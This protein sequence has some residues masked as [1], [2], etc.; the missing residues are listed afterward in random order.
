MPEQYQQP[1]AS[2]GQ[3]LDTD[4]IVAIATAPG[5]AGIGIL[6]LSGPLAVTIAERV[7]GPG[8]VPRQATYRKFRDTTGGLLDS[9]LI[10]YFP[11]PHS[12]TGEDVVEFQG[13]GSPV[14]LQMI[15][16]ELLELGARLARPGEF[17][18][19]AFLNGKMDLAQAEAVADLISSASVEAARGANR[20]LS[21]EFSAR[22]HDIDAQVLELRI[23]VEAA[24]DFADEDIDLLA[25][26]QVAERIGRIIE[27]LNELRDA[28]A[29]GVILRDGI[30]LALIGPPNVGK[31]SLLNRLAGESRAIVS[32]VPGTTRDLIRADLDLG[33]LPVE[34]VD[35]AGLRESNDAV[36]QEG[37]RRALSE[38][39]DADIII[40]ISDL[41]V[42][43]EWSFGIEPDDYSRVLRVENKIDLSGA[44]R[45]G[46]GASVD[47]AMPVS[48]LTGEGI[49]SLRSAIRARAGFAPRGSLFTARKRHLVGIDD[50]LSSVKE[51]LVLATG[52][53]SGEL[54]AEEL[55]AAHS[56]LGEIVG[57][58]SSDALLGEIFSRFC[59][60]K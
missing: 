47:G 5:Q 45:T 9:G 60:G 56:A 55:K 13:H 58:M 25:E 21:G 46:E 53:L 30:K 51:A 40:L 34:I 8:L 2:S 7:A 24:I 20:S 26:G 38:A 6:R 15:Q 31:S 50:A 12:F 3:T 52:G 11:A 22:V 59:I 17:T 4:T 27:T 49:E 14:A 16:D 10:L 28:C 44:D 36:E 35:T 43:T 32:D 1:A 18:E 39:K 54:I 29:Q 23:F 33:G 42:S 19:R 41:T 57:Q 37:V 48:A